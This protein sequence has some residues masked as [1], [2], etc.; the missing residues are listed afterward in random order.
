[1]CFLGVS[2]AAEILGLF[3]RF[4][5]FVSGFLRV[6]KVSRILGV[7]EGFLGIFEETKT[8]KDREG[9]FDE[10]GRLDHF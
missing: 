6:R 4:L 10:N 9:H 1:M 2:L 8:K 5:L 3:G 7:F